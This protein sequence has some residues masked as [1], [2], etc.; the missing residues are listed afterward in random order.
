MRAYTGQVPDTEPA[1]DWRLE[2]AC[3]KEDPEDFFPVGAT[4]RAKALER[5]AK[6]VCWHCPSQ[7]ECLRWAL[8]T[9]EEYGVW[10]G[11]TEGERRK[12]RRRSARAA[13]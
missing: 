5:H 12:L 10:G 13:S 7:P 1:V 11:L 3:R 8:E 4:P 2:A 9:G 6:V